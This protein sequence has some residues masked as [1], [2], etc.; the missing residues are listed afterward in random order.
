MKFHASCCE[1]SDNSHL[2]SIDYSHSRANV[3]IVAFCS[4]LSPEESTH[5]LA[6]STN[7]VHTISLAQPLFC[8][9]PSRSWTVCFQHS[10][11]AY[12]GYPSRQRLSF[13]IRIVW[14]ICDDND[15]THAL[16]AAST[17]NSYAKSRS[18]SYL[19]PV[20]STNVSAP[21]NKL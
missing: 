21:L 16:E 1:S 2:A 5:L 13:A 19:E 8:Y 7:G 14:R 18:R 12:Q 10:Q 4:W 3:I 6:S 11:L 15:A 20:S 17:Y 9:V